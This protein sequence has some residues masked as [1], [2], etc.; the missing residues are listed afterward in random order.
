MVFKKNNSGL[1]VVEAKIGGIYEISKMVHLFINVFVK[2]LPNF[3][4]KITSK[5]VG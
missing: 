2:I 1:G 3:C 5:H 4:P